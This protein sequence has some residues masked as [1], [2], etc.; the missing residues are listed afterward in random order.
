MSDEE[1]SKK[2]LK[3][4][5]WFINHQ[6]STQLTS[7]NLAVSRAIDSVNKNN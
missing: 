6:V 4:I 1:L 5:E 2:N 3:M 7:T